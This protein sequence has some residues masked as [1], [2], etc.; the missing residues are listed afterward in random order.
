[1]S[2]FFTESDLCAL[3]HII[4]VVLLPNFSAA[5]YCS[6]ILMAIRK[7][8]KPID[9]YIPYPE[10]TKSKDSYDFGYQN[11][12]LAQHVDRSNNRYDNF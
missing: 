4:F 11:F 2:N 1:M 5:S 7:Y 6:S 9:S 10:D 8:H 12:L 3:K